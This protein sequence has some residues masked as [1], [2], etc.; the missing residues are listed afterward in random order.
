MSILNHGTRKHF[1]FDFQEQKGLW[2]P[3]NWKEFLVNLRTMR[4]NNDAPV[5]SMG[6]HMSLD[7]NAPPKVILSF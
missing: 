2:E 5:D 3:A 4:A 1:Y 7:E 6:C